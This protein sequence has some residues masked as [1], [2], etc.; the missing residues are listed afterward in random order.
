MTKGMPA[1]ENYLKL[2]K[3]GSFVSNNSQE[4]LKYKSFLA[5]KKLLHFLSKFYILKMS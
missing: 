3:F 2:V 4:L 1:F 5:L